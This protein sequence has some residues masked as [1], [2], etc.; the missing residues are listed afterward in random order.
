MKIYNY[1][2]S[3]LE[4]PNE[5]SLCFN[6]TGCN[7]KCID[8]HSKFLWNIDNGWE[9]D[10][11]YFSKILEKYSNY[12]SYV[13]FMGGEWFEEDLIKML[14]ISKEKGLKNCLFTGRNDIKENIKQYL[15]LLKLGGFIKELG[16]LESLN[17]NQ[18]MI[19]LK[20]GNCLNYLF[21][22]NTN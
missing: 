12:I 10:F 22:K 5:I 19:E 1:E 4:I 9:L 6:V 11:E 15:D 8:C 17:T 2:I 14:K 16:G 21:Q 3:T 7:V 18:K 20:T 13:C